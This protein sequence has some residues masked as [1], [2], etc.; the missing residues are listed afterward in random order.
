MLRLEAISK[1]YHRPGSPP[2]KALEDVTLTIAQGE[3]VA[4]GGP[5]GSGKS[6]LLFTLGGLMHPTSGDVR[7]GDTLVYDLYPAQRSELRLKQIGFVFQSFNLIPYL[8]AIENVALP[9]RLAGKRSEAATEAAR[10]LLDQVGLATRLLHRPAELSVGERQRVAIARA[11]VNAPKLLLADEPTG[12]LDGGNADEV[13]SILE[14][15]NAAGLTVVVVT[16][17][18]AV[19]ERAGRAVRLVSGRVLGESLRHPVAQAARA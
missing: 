8:T 3:F 10:D 2:V 14:G 6:T 15:L 16:H 17:D 7:L 12:N 19:A 13:M 9:A 4:I 1:I 5:S 18:P 11:L